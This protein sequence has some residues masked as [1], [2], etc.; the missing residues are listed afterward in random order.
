MESASLKSVQISSVYVID[1]TAKISLA[2]LTL[3]ETAFY[4]SHM[5]LKW[6]LE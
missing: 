5:I 3:K 1:S 4:W 2:Q 6:A